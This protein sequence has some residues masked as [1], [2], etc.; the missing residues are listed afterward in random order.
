MIRNI[1]LLQNIGTFDS[2]SAA[3]SLDFKSLNLVY[4]DN[5]RGKTTV[6]AVFRSLAKNDPLPIIERHRI[7]SQHPPKVVLRSQDDASDLMFR[8]RAWNRVPA[9]IKVFDDYFI[10]ENV[11]SG[12]NVETYHRQNLHELIL[13][14]EG[15]ALN[16]RVQ[17]LVLKIRQHNVALVEKEKAFPEH[18]RYGL[19]LSEF[20]ALPVVSNVDEKIEVVER[21]LKAAQNQDTVRSAPIFEDLR[22]P[23]FNLEAIQETL[24]KDLPSLDKA[25]EARVLTHM[26]TLGEGGESWV[27]DGMANRMQDQDNVCPFC[28]QDIT[29]LDLIDHYRAYFSAEYAQLKELVAE[30]V[31]DINRGHAEGTQ[32]LFVATVGKAQQCAQFWGDYCDV[33]EIEVKSDTIL[34]DWNAARNAVKKLLEVKQAAP[35]DP[36]EMSDDVLNALRKYNAHKDRIALINQEL[37]ACNGRIGEVKEQVET[38]T[39]S[40]IALE[41]NKLKAS[42][43]RYREDIV[44]LCDDYKK[45][46]IA[47]ACTEVKRA[48]ARAALDEYQAEVFPLLQNGVNNY[49]QLFNAGFSVD[50]LVSR[51]IGSGSGSTC[52]YNV[53]INNEPVPVRNS[54]NPQGGRSF[55]NTLSSGDRN[56]LALA[57]FFSSLDRNPK[58]CDTTVVIDDPKSSLDDHRSMTTV[59]TIQELVEKAKQVIVLSHDKPFLCRIWERANR[60]EYCA[61]QIAANGG[62]STIRSWEVSEDAITEHDKRHILLQDFAGTQAGDP[63]RVATAIRP[64]LE[65]YFRVACPA[66]FPPRKL[67][68]AFI[69]KCRQRLGSNDEIMAKK[70]ITELKNLVDYA[71]LFH[72]DTNSSLETQMINATE[73]L[74]FVERTLDFVRLPK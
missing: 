73:L 68:G 36:I 70:R 74:G 60:K 10:D 50:S 7:G 5:A 13:G 44:P 15:V 38:A 31:K 29:G 23:A 40:Q 65:G 14:D 56:T 69:E 48:E 71:N 25:A 32:T 54:K 4:A 72:H 27:A 52:T 16:R 51:K 18:E 63:R 35:L 41:L 53:V 39:T 42:K 8:E 66:H 33:P 22:L 61:L 37:K 20:C 62:E 46:Q 26:R 1:K 67:L 9:N 47:K 28:G 55:R 21:T 43:A 11:Y 49:L 64:H 58:L 45:E 2:D 19:P 17:A 12:L 3:A 34:Q 24:A 30:M 59:H 57:L 6:A